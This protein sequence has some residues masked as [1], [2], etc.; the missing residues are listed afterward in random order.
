MASVHEVLESK[1]FDPEILM[2]SAAESS[3]ADQRKLVQD[4]VAS[5]SPGAK[6]EIGDPEQG[7]SRLRV[8][9][10]KES[11]AGKTK[12]YGQSYTVEKSLPFICEEPGGPVLVIQ[13]FVSSSVDLKGREFNMV[14]YDSNGIVLSRKPCEVYPLTLDQEAQKKLQVRSRIYL[15]RASIKPDPNIRRY[16]IAVQK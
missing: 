12:I 2:Q 7:V 3:T 16:E 10:T 4:L 6:C 13:E 15:V 14:L 11:G 5:K 9:A 1:E 8:A